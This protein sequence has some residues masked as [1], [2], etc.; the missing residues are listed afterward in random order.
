MKENRLA[1]NETQQQLADA[2]GAS[3]QTI[4]KIEKGIPVKSSQLM[5]AIAA[6]YNLPVDEVFYSAQDDLEEQIG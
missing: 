5:F 2:I 6:H 3:R 1:H 4:I